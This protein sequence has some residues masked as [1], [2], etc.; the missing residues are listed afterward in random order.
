MS[1][2]LT[3]GAVFLASFE[4]WPSLLKYITKTVP[5]FQ[6]PSTQCARLLILLEKWGVKTLISSMQSQLLGT[7]S[8]HSGV[9]LVSFCLQ[10]L[11]QSVSQSENSAFSVLKWLIFEKCHCPALSGHNTQWKSSYMSLKVNRIKFCW[12]RL[13]PDL[14]L[15]LS[16]AIRVPISSKSGHILHCASIAYAARI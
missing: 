6:S 2:S 3:K 7:I 1:I 8:S 13:H 10:I 5:N 14:Q 9:K 11:S 12:A 15:W 4:V 16:M